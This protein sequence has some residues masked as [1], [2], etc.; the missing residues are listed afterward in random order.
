MFLQYMHG[1]VGDRRVIEEQMDLWRREYRSGATGF[2]GS[3]SGFTDD[4]HFVALA[5]FATEEAANENAHRP[6]QNAWWEK[7]AAGFAGEISFIDC[8]EVDLLMGGGSDE[9]TFVQIMRGKAVDP[10]GLRAASDEME[11]E[12]AKLRPDVV[13]MVCGW[14]GDRE[15]VQAV[16]FTSEEEARQGESATQD[17]PQA[18]EWD[19]MFE[20]PMTYIDLHDPHFD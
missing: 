2:L 14:H 10:D 5:R 4:G 3:T 11:S 17:D 15:F 9:A 16:Y 18:A 8:P 20:G 1:K 19:N 12:M 13:G 6:E 7:F